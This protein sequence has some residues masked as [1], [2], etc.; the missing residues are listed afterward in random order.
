MKFEYAKISDAQLAEVNALQEKLSQNG[1]KI[2]LLAVEEQYQPA[3]LSEEELAK[4]TE[5]EQTLSKA[6]RQVVLLGLSK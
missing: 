1:S 6:G 4:V 3:Q 5:L 2:L